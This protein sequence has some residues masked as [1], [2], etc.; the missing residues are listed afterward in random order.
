MRT[1]AIGGVILVGLTL[2][3]WALVLWADRRR[4][5]KAAERERRLQLAR[6]AQGDHR[7]VIEEDPE[8]NLLNERCLGCGLT[9]TLGVVISKAVQE[10]RREDERRR[11][12]GEGNGAPGGPGGER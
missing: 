9:H 12:R 11:R 7:T 2:S 5:R 8:T 10:Q 6:C 4:A 3:W 1:D